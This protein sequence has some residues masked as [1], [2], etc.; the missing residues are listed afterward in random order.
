MSYELADGSLSTEYKV[1][2]KFLV[3]GIDFPFSNHSVVELYYDDGTSCPLFRLVN[4]QCE[5]K[6]CDGE[7]G[8]YCDWYNLSKLVLDQTSVNVSQKETSDYSRLLATTRCSRRT[9]DQKQF[10]INRNQR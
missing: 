5:Y 8:A 4:G 2:D 1:W 10:K 9:S 7:Y 3:D 6:F